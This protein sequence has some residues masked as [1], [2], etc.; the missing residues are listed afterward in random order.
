MVNETKL[1][2]KYEVHQIVSSVR[3]R[4]A[5]PPT[6]ISAEINEDINLPYTQEMLDI[7]AIHNNQ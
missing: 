1:G 7:C 5:F 6:N 4:A 2:I 3:L